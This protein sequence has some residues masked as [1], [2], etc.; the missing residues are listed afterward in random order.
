MPRARAR[1]GRNLED[2]AFVQA[3]LL[4]QFITMAR[5]VQDAESGFT[6]DSLAD[7]LE[8]LRDQRREMGD[9]LRPRVVEP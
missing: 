8:Q 4:D 1:F 2:A 7:L 6:R 5:E 9:V 3:K